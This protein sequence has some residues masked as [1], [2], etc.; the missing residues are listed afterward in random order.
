MQY[1]QYY[2]DLFC[3]LLTG[4]EADIL[5]L[6]EKERRKQ[7]KKKRE[8]KNP[9]RQGREEKLEFLLYFH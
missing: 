4:L 1:S 7:E 3:Y 5:T 6:G 2:R 9:R 8:E